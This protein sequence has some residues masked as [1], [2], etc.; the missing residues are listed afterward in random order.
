MRDDGILYVCDLVNV[1]ENG[2][3]P[4]Q[5]LKI[6]NKYW[7]ENRVVGYNR[8]YT[9][10]G[11]NQQVDR[12]VRIARDYGVHIGQY[13]VLGNGEQF[14]V[15]MV[16]YGQDSNDR[17]KMIQSKYY[18]QPKIVDLPYTEITLSRLENYY[19]VLTS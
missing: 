2:D 12:L 9:A 19:D 14:R 3:M 13:V 5:K 16:S 17:T 7:F 11:V 6:V 8:F 1:A 18:R 10:Q 15:D 4:R